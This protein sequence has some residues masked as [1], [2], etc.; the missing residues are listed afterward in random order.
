LNLSNNP[1]NYLPPQVQRLIARQKHGQN[2]YKD[3]QSVH[4]SGIQASFRETVHR[5]TR[6]PCHISLDQTL[7]EI[8]QSTLPEETKISLTEYA[9]SQDIHGELQLTFGELLVIVW[10]RVRT[11]PSQ[12]ELQVILTNEMKDALCMCFTGRITRLVNTLSGFDPDVSITITE[13]EQLSNLVM[14]TK[15]KIVPYDLVRHRALFMEEAQ[16]RQYSSQ[17][18]EE[19]LKYLE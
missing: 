11:H 10:N 14:L 17:T 8:L 12:K 7:E 16:Q 4:N 19:W 3:K 15:E 6:V 1:M 18:I 13:N 5:L 9:S 2:V